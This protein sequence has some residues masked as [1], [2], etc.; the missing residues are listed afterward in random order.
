MIN[1]CGVAKEKKQEI[2]KY[3]FNING[4]LYSAKMSWPGTCPLV[5]MK[6]GNSV[7]P[8]LFII[9]TEKIFI[10][11]PNEKN[12]SDLRTQLE[13]ILNGNQKI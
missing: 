12:S 11:N 3:E 6:D 1:Y 4:V 7:E 5:C 2:E 9:H 10:C 13:N 8:L